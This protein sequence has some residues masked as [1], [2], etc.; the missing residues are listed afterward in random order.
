[1]NICLVF[2][3]SNSHWHLTGNTL[4][5]DRFIRLTSDVQSRAGG[6]WNVLPVPYADWEIHV[7]F[8][9]HGENKNFFGDG[10]VI[11]YVREPKLT[12]TRKYFDEHV[13]DQIFHRSG[14]WLSRSFSWFRNIFRYL[15]KQ[16]HSK[17]SI[18]NFWFI[19][20]IT[21]LFFRLA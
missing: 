20:R 21:S 3:T 8:R 11:W 14:F 18:C 9:I 10:L 7:Q 19:L 4:V 1:M 13:I 12:G 16:P 15:C 2:S 17:S 6:L 5:T